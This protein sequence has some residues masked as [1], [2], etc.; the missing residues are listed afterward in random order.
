MNGE[1]TRFQRVK[2]EENSNGKMGD[3]CLGMGELIK[4]PKWWVEGSIMWELR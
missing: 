1:E 3:P 4:G 2:G